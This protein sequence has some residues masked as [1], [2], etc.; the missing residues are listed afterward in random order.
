[1][2]L[3]QVLA[4][5]APQRCTQAGTTMSAQHFPSACLVLR[6]I[7]DDRHAAAA[8]DD[9]VWA[10]GIAGQTVEGLLLGTTPN[11]LLQ[12]GETGFQCRAGRLRQG[13]PGAATGAEN[14]NAPGDGSV[15][16]RAKRHFVARY[17]RATALHWQDPY[18]SPQ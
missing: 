15:S 13:H 7:L 4:Q 14:G 8:A 6:A 11:L 1:M 3:F 18:N 5:S 12:G 2:I 16:F 10:T 9:A 17:L